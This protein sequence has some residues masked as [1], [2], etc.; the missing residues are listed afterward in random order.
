MIPVAEARQLIAQAVHPLAPVA[1]SLYE[2]VGL[3][4]AANVH[5]LCNVPPFHQS[6]MDGY[7]FRFSDLL[8][9]DTLHVASEVQAGAWIDTPLQPGQAAR[10]FTGAPV[11][12]GADTVIMQEK[13]IFLSQNIT[14][15][16]KN[17]LKG[18][19][20][21]P[22]GSQTRI[23]DLL[24]PAGVRLSPAALGLLAGAGHASAPVLPPPV[25]GIINTGQELTPPGQPLV[26]GRIYES[27]SYAL[28]AVL[29]QRGIRDIR[30]RTVTDDPAAIREAIQALLAD[31]DLLLL[32]G[33]VSVGNYDFVQAALQACGVQQIFHKVQ[34]KPGKPLFFGTYGPKPVFGLPGNPAAV[35]TCFY[36]YVDLALERLCGLAQKPLQE[37]VLLAPVPKKA[38]L[39][40]YLKGRLE[41]P[42]VRALGAQESYQ[43]GSFAD[44]DCLIHLAAEL[45]NPPAGTVVSVRTL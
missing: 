3:C 36:E 11:P 9:F 18:A 39:H 14:I 16:D 37:R 32:T 7:A 17:I 33:G 20:I 42:G 23:Q 21:R 30:L 26:P 25:A 2:A 38:G 45:E 22:C 28:K 27:N 24:L 1:V 44:A 29:Q 15:Q 4:L 5:A 12:P 35:L 34:Q 41:G 10:I 40:V 6:A 13:T 8:L 19:N 43:M 31:C